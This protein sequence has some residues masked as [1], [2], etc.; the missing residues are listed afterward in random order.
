M[1]ADVEIVFCSL[2]SGSNFLLLN[3]VTISITLQLTVDGISVAGEIWSLFDFR[4]ALTEIIII[5]CQ[6]LHNTVDVEPPYTASEVFFLAEN[7]FVQFRWLLRQTADKQMI[8]HEEFSWN[9][10]DGSIEKLAWILSV[11]INANCCEMTL[12]VDRDVMPMSIVDFCRQ[13]DLLTIA[14]TKN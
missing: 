5:F 11:P 14:S 3:I 4:K 7:I 13:R 12:C 8:R 9:L 2:E 10:N 6:I 1:F